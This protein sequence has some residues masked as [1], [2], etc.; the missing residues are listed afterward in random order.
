[1]VGLDIDFCN[2]I[3][4]QNVFVNFAAFKDKLA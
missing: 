2:L 3:G 4:V 1:M